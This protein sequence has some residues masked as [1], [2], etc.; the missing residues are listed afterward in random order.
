MQPF[1]LLVSII[2]LLS[3]N[4]PAPHAYLA[5]QEVVVY[6]G[7][8]DA[9]GYVGSA[10]LADSRGAVVIETPPGELHCEAWY[11]ARRWEGILTLLKTTKRLEVVLGN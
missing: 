8:D 5:C 9:R 1:T 7:D 3:P 6:G 11:G 2:L 10:S 4:Q